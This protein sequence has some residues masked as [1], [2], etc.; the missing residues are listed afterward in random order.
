MLVGT[1]VF[2]KADKFFALSHGHFRMFPGQILRGGPQCQKSGKPHPIRPDTPTSCRA[3]C[4]SAWRRSREKSMHHIRSIPA[5]V[6]MHTRK[7]NLISFTWSDANYLELSRIPVD[8]RV[9]PGYLFSVGRATYGSRMSSALSFARLATFCE[10]SPTE[11]SFSVHLEVL[12]VY[13]S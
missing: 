12:Y 5:T 6:K 9:T 11:A 10:S 7:A 4:S 13:S 2:A 8:Q 3:D 1:R